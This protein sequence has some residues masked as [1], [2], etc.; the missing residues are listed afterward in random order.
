MG[1]LLYSGWVVDQEREG[2]DRSKWIRSSFCVYSCYIEPGL[3]SRLLPL[4][5]SSSSLQPNPMEA[6]QDILVYQTHMMRN[7]TLG[8]YLSPSF[9]PPRYI[10]VV[11]ALFKPF[12]SNAL[13]A[14]FV[15]EAYLT[16][17]CRRW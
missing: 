1:A 5:V 11:N 17:N 9:S 12:M 4:P 14:N 15:F 10:G 3:D 7:S 6:I 2:S 8:P 16:G 13:R